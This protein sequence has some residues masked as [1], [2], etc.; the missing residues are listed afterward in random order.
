MARYKS[1]RE[2]ILGNVQLIR[3]I[4]KGKAMLKVPEHVMGS[5]VGS[6]EC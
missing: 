4:L 1:S 3:S 6:I 2:K 5:L